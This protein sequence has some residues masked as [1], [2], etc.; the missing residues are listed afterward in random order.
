MLM[1]MPTQWAEIVSDVPKEWASAQGHLSGA[2]Q[3]YD[4]FLK[5]LRATSTPSQLDDFGIQHL[6][7]G[8][9]E[10][11]Q[12]AHGVKSLFAAA[13]GFRYL[14]QLGSFDQEQM[15][16]PAD[17]RSGRCAFKPLHALA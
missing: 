16:V 17:K 9:I 14:P 5:H 12:G 8:Q 3:V 7:I 6:S 10:L 11:Q 2:L 4:N 15:G 1:G 13:P